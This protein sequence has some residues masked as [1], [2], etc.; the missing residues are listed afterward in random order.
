MAGVFQL[1]KISRPTLAFFNLDLLVNPSAT[2]FVAI[3]V[4]I[5][6]LSPGYLSLCVLCKENSVRDV[7]S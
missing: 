1:G 7:L 6:F 3:E 5:V 4:A 2:I